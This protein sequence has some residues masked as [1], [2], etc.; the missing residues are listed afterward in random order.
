[1]NPAPGPEAATMIPASAGA[2]I[3]AADVVPPVSPFARASWAAGTISGK[4]ALLT[5][6][7]KPSAQP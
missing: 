2:A 6:P 5:G 1:M 3:A 7:K 4:T